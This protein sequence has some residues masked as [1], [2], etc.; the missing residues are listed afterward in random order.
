G[1]VLGV[2]D[3]MGGAAAGDIASKLACAALDQVMR[4]HAPLRSIEAAEAALLQAVTSANRSILDH[5]K[6]HPEKRGMGT[7]MTAAALFDSELAVVQVG[8][9]RAYLR[10]GSTL[11]QLTMDQNVVGQMIATGRIAAD[12]ARNVKQRNMLL[13]AI[14][15]QEK[16]GPD[17]VRVRVQAGDVLMLC[18]DGLTGPLEDRRLLELMLQHQDPVRT[19]RALTEAACALG[20]PDNV[21]VVIARF[22]GEPGASLGPET[23]IAFSR[24]GASA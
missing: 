18:S 7:T 4:A 23:T 19:C 1:T 11:Q 10:R 8:D 13:E 9:S 22:I 5:A 16:V 20:G 21:T 14:G 15:V 3:G 12:Q 17:L 2:C 24:R 6:A